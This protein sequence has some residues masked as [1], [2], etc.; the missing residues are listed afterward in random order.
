MFEISIGPHGKA[1]RFSVSSNPVGLAYSVP[2]LF[3]SCVCLLNIV[4]APL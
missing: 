1:K 3:N 2:D 4:F